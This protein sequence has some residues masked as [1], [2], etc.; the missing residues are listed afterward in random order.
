MTKRSIWFWQRMVTPHMAYLAEAM[1]RRGH[2]VTYVAEE[3]LGDERA[4]LGW[5]LPAMQDVK[6]HFVTNASEAARLVEGALGN[7]IH[8]TQ[9]IRSNGY[10]AA[11]QT[12]I[13][14]QGQRHF[15]IMETIDR[16]GA[17][18]LFKP[19][20]YFWHL[21]R[22][23]YGLD[24]I[25][26]I[27]ASSPAWFRWLAPESVK[28]YPFA[29]FLAEH[30][31]QGVTNYHSRFRFLFVGQ[32]IPRKRVDFFLRGL[33]NLSEGDFEVEL[34]GDGPMRRELQ[35]LADSLLPGRVSF[36]GVLPMSMIPARMAEADCLV[37]PSS[38][39]GWGAVVSEALMSGTPV[40]CSAACGANVVVRASGTG[41]VFDTWDIGALTKLLG[42]IL[43]NGKVKPSERES[44]RKWARCLG[45]D[46]GAAY[47]EELI[48]AR[49]GADAPSPPWG[50][51]RSP[52]R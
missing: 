36:S 46:A 25:L 41:G 51:V 15:S 52:R 30:R 13:K 39:D 42:S 12:A 3:D 33:G 18:R 44:L 1:A 8:L 31:R 32:F 26:A 16:R 4:A 17:A 19:V 40:I 47:L 28:I 6:L 29:Y 23:R 22:W 49:S 20:L 11:A 35:E 38:H 27:G 43:G 21:Q 2:D 7:T 9:G 34:V 50:R 10:V 14:A 45:V 24:G 48:Q 37:L 5:Q